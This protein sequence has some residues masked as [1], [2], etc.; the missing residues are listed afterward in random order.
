M[1]N[2]LSTFT[3]GEPVRGDLILIHAFPLDH[4]LWQHLLDNPPD[5]FRVIAMDLPGFGSSPIDVIGGRDGYDMGAVAELIASTARSHGIERAVFGGCSMGGYACFAVLSAF[6]EMVS[7]LLLSDTRASADSDAAREGRMAVIEAVERL[8]ISAVASSM[9]SRLLGETT[10]STNPEL[11][12]KIRS[13][14]TDQNPDAVIGALAAMARRRDSSDLLGGIDVP[15][16]VVVGS[17]DALV[18][19]DEAETLASAISGCELEVLD[20]V[21]HLPALEA[22]G[23]FAV[24]VKQLLERVSSP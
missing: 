8:G 13:I 4:R 2:L 1:T 10:L 5:G 9:P 11:V 17:E 18:T 20:A 6:P 7:G 14:I 22:P 21:G 24:I 3:S 15:T 16:T 19:T 23:E 12:E